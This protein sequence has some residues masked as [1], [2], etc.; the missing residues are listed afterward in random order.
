MIDFR[1]EGF[2]I[3]VLRLHDLAALPDLTMLGF[4]EFV[5]VLEFQLLQI[6]NL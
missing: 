3:L 1:S 5:I 6:S 2:I 4:Y